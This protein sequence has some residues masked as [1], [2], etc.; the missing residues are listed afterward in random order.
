[1]LVRLVSCSSTQS[2]TLGPLL[3]CNAV[4]TLLKGLCML[5]CSSLIIRY[6]FHCC[7][8][9]SAFALTPVNV[10]R[11][12]LFILPV[13]EAVGAAGATAACCCCCCCWCAIMIGNSGWKTCGGSGSTSGGGSGASSPSKSACSTRFKYPG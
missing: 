9:A 4:T 1:M 10:S 12:V 11:G 13:N 2:F 6:N 8:K 3:K 5:T 7:M